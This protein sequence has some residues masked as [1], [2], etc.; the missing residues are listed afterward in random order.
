MPTVR[1]PPSSRI[2][3]CKGRPAAPAPMTT[4][5]SSL[6]E[7]E[8]PKIDRGAAAS[9]TLIVTDRDGL[10]GMV[11]GEDGLS[12]MEIIRNTGAGEPFALCGG[13]C[14]CA[15]CHVYV[16][17]A[18]V[19]ALPPPAAEESDLLE[20]TGHRRETSRLSCQIVFKTELSGLRVE[21]APAD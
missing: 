13:C 20:S 8:T 19:K 14:S 3:G 10:E 7:V 9:P 15:T 11:E 1:G 5:T 17:P 16:D 2:E 4:E 6:P 18:F 21:I 12:V